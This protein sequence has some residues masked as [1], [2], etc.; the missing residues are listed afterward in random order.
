MTQD[1]T[2]ASMSATRA[3]RMRVGAVASATGRSRGDVLRSLM[4]GEVVGL[5]AKVAQKGH[6]SFRSALRRTSCFVAPPALERE[7]GR[8]S[9]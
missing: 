1:C 4:T 6:C 5:P 3:A 8:G 7:T 9:R 2:I